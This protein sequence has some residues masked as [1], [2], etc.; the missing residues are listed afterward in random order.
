MKVDF[1]LA[2][3]IRN[4]MTMSINERPDRTICMLKVLFHSLSRKSG[5]ALNNP[6][7]GAYWD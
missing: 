3:K 5:T 7:H 1:L 6:D 4:S 2:F